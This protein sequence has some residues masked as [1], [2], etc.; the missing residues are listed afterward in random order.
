[1]G[2]FH[3]EAL[4]NAVRAFEL[5]THHYDDYD[6]RSSAVHHA[7]HPDAYPQHDTPSIYLQTYLDQWLLTGGGVEWSGNNHTTWLRVVMAAADAVMRGDVT[8]DYYGPKPPYVDPERT[9]PQPIIGIYEYGSRGDDFL[10][11]D[12]YAVA[13]YR[14]SHRG[15]GLLQCT[16]YFEPPGIALGPT[17]TS[18]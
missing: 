9:Y 2:N 3:S 10:D 12:Y 4:D 17:S 8:C 13:A 7:E 14:W 16:D 6:I 15:S 1:M 11:P 5:F 18:E